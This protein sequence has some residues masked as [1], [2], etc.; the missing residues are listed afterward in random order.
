MVHRWEK[1]F[2]W[3]RCC[4]VSMQRVRVAGEPGAQEV[5]G[6][7]SL[8]GPGLV[9]L[10]AWEPVAG[11]LAVDAPLVFVAHC[12]AEP[13]LLELQLL[14]L[15]LL[16]QL[17]AQGPQAW[18]EAAGVHS[19][20]WVLM[21][22]ETPGVCWPQAWWL[23]FLAEPGAPAC[24]CSDWLLSERRGWPCPARAYPGRLRGGVRHLLSGGCGSFQPLS[25]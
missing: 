3:V 16:E 7:D 8:C 15:Q 17:A 21:E 14:E 13:L 22:R 18:R 20:C 5:M 9:R 4:G 23:P 24:C 11:L 10:S 19:L 12:S 2:G 6:G 25:R 1:P